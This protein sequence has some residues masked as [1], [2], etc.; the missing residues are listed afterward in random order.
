MK[1]SL[2]YSLLLK[3]AMLGIAVGIVLWIGWSGSEHFQGRVI[4]SGQSMKANETPSPLDAEFDRNNADSFRVDLNRGTLDELQT[5]PG[6][7]P[8][9]A[10]RIVRHRTS[11]GPFRDVEEL[12][13]VKGIGDGR[14]AH[15]RRFVKVDTL[16]P[17]PS[18][19]P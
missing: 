15:L 3:M 1:V 19:Q 2:L 9:L 18:H 17:S 10:A 7:G 6:I 11:Y 4:E 13:S 5:L 16:A 14:F 12:T 8:H